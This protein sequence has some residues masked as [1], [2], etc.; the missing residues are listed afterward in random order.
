M[1]G[2]FGLGANYAQGK[3][4]ASAARSAASVPVGVGPMFA[5]MSGQF[6]LDEAVQQSKAYMEQSL[7]A[8]R[9]GVADAIQRQRQV[10][11]FVEAQAASLVSGGLT[12]SGS[13][14]AVT[15]E[16]RQQGD[17]EVKRMYQRAEAQSRFL[18]LEGLSVLRKGYF[19]RFSGNIQ[20]QMS[21]FDHSIKSSQL[22]YQA[23]LAD[24]NAN[25][26]LFAAGGDMLLGIGQKAI[27]GAFGGGG[28]GGLNFGGFAGG[29]SFGNSR[30][31]PSAG[32][33]R[34][35]GL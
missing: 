17:Q 22:R 32:A 14:L 16:S 18:E 10:N 24:Y 11:S 12:L 2:L 7:L 20:A 19:D 27:G 15:E 30:M 23:K 29:G 35:G 6:A 25:M 26:G 33:F 21:E 13:G 28:G 31:V 5:R 4:S 1:A 3:A 34:M 8:Y 9:E